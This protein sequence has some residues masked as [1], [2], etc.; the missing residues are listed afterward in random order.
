MSARS[1]QIWGARGMVG[2]WETW[3]TSIQKSFEL[4][5]KATYRINGANV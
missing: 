3:K 2:N 4:A 1:L 5:T